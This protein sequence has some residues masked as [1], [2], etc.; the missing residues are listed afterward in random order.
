MLLIFKKAKLIDKLNDINQYSFK[1]KY[2][3]GYYLKL[4]ELVKLKF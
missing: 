3:L 1:Q 2:I 4:L